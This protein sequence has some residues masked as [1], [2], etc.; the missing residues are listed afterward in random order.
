MAT[1]DRTKDNPWQ[2][3]TPPGTSE[4]TMH[5]DEKDGVKILVCTVGKTVL[6]YDAR[7]IDDLHAMLKKRA[8]W[9]DLGG[10]RR[11]EAGKGRHG[12][13]LG[14]LAVERRRRLVWSQEGAARAIR[15]LRSA[16][17]GSTRPGR[18]GAQ[19]EEQ[20]NARQVA[21]VLQCRVIP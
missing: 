1:L 2:L 11:A 10:G 6:H 21:W 7:C 15:R 14:P 8:D 20:S 18:A 12:G 17:H 19:S 9:M 16:P 5:M 13:G 3:K 4:Y